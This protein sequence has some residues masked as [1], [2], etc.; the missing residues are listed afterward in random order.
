MGGTLVDDSGGGT[1]LVNLSISPPPPVATLIGDL[2]RRARGSFVVDGVTRH[3]HLTVFMARFD[4]SVLPDLIEHVAESASGLQVLR[5]HHAGYRITKNSYFEASYERTEELLEL[6]ELLAQVV[7]PFRRVTDAPRVE[8]YFVTSEARQ[9]RHAA[10]TGYDL[11]GPDFR[12]HITITRFTD[13]A[14]RPLPT[15]AD[16]LSFSSRE[17]SVYAADRLGA[18]TRLLWRN[19]S[20]TS[21]N[22]R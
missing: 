12:P 20:P 22:P 3:P 11:Y 16:E 8:D 17:L 13:G 15:V 14:P 4:L 19:G 1:V 7:R 5:L 10:L 21:G 18:A 2:S 6:Q 9:M